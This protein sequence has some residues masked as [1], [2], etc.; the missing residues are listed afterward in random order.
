MVQCYD[1]SQ[2]HPQWLTTNK[3]HI[4]NLCHI[5]PLQMSSRGTVDS[6]V[7]AIYCYNLSQ[8]SDT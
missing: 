1:Y 6:I 5:L 8:H 2:P 3:S 4:C 7:I